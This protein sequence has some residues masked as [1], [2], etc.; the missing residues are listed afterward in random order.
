MTA[1]N[2][3]QSPPPVSTPTF[4]AA[5]YGGGDG[6]SAECRRGNRTHTGLTAHRILS[7]A[8]LDVGETMFPP[9]APFFISRA[10][11]PPAHLPA[12]KARLRRRTSPFQDRRVPKVG[13]EPTR[14]SRPT[15]F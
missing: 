3:G 13:I 15:G 7:P 6:R 5:S 10:S 9:P 1:F 8:R 12:G 2:P 14:A 4:T 11:R